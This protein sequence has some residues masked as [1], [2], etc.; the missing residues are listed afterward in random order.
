MQKWLKI[1]IAI[2]IHILPQLYVAVL[3]HPTSA[4]RALM[5]SNFLKITMMKTVPFTAI[6][7]VFYFLS[8]RFHSAIQYVSAAACGYGSA[9]VRLA[10]FDCLVQA[11]FATSTTISF[12]STSATSLAVCS[13]SSA[14]ARTS[15]RARPRTAAA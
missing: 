9:R 11:R 3:Y 6:L 8:T 2:F 13:P 7:P 5:A 1:A 4:D 12:R 14:R 15:P 10:L